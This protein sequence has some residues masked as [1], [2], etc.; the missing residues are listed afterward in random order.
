MPP[1]GAALCGGAGG[2][3][4]GVGRAVWAA[5]GS[6]RAGGDQPGPPTRCCCGADAGRAAG[7]AAWGA[8]C[9]S[10]TAPSSLAV[11]RAS[12]HHWGQRGALP[13]HQ[14]SQ[15]VLCQPRT[16]WVPQGGRAVLRARAGRCS[17]CPALQGA[18]Q[19]RAQHPALVFAFSV[20]EI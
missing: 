3:C 6:P 13:E 14:E 4:P 10:G 9:G 19:C 16:Y 12:C 15:A 7:C 1:V 11:R 5:R 17:L 20:P 8:G 2:C 18:A